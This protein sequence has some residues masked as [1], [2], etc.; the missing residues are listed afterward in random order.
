MSII[1]TQA[2]KQGQV[3]KTQIDALKCGNAPDWQEK[4]IRLIRSVRFD[5]PKLEF[6]R[7]IG[8]GAIDIP[9]LDKMRKAVP[10]STTNASLQIRCM[11]GQ[12]LEIQQIYQDTHYVLTHGQD[13]CGYLLS[14][15]YKK[16][17]KLAGK[18]LK[19]F[20]YLRPHTI[21]ETP[22]PL[23]KYA[24]DVDDHDL[25]TKKD[26]L[27]CSTNPF[28]NKSY[29]SALS[30]FSK[31]TNMSNFEALVLEHTGQEAHFTPNPCDRPGNLY[32]ICIP[33]DKFPRIGYLSYPRGI[34]CKCSKNIHETLQEAQKGLKTLECE[35]VWGSQARLSLSNLTPDCRIFALT[36]FTKSERKTMKSK[37]DKM[38]V[39]SKL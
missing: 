39:R 35:E 31:S 1:N 37:I 26:L 30:F 4:A 33:K 17:A 2:Y 3:L 28:C 38:P 13:R 25:T 29:E 11:L 7:L 34:P 8:A 27:A 23:T 21:H 5:D 36:P 19:Y 32:V 9:T 16:D 12:A 15:I 14:L 10:P 20:K 24:A 22:K 18:N 6:G